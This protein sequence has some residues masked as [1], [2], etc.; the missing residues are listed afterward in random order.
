M[1]E[2][3]INLCLHWRDAQDILGVCVMSLAKL[4]KTTV[5]A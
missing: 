2:A 4:G 1:L 3:E 5:L